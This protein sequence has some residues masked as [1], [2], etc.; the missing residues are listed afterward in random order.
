MSALYGSKFSLTLPQD[1]IIRLEAEKETIGVK[2]RSRM[3]EKCIRYYFD[4][5]EEDKNLRSDVEKL[6]NEIEK[7]K[8][9]VYLV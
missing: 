2:S 4:N 7:I 1:I 3:I 6:R 8:E 5:K 9:T